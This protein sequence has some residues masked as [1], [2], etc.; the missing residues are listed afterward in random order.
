MVVDTK[1]EKEGLAE[2]IVFFLRSIANSYAAIFFSRSSW[3][4]VFLLCLTMLYPSQGLC[5]L[6]C[7]M[8]VN[9]FAISLELNRYKTEIGLYGFNAVLVGNALGA[10][11]PYN[12]TLI[13]LVFAV[14]VV[15]LLLT[16][17]LET[18][19]Q[20]Y[21]LPSLCTPFLLCLWLVLLVFQQF[22]A[23]EAGFDFLQMQ[24]TPMPWVEQISN[25]SF[26]QNVPRP[27]LLFFTSLGYIFFQ[28]NYLTGLLL[29]I[30]LLFFSRISATISLIGFL[31]A[32]FVYEAFDF[33]I[34][35]VP[36][37]YFGFNFIFT[38]MAVGG[39][40]LVS[41]KATLLWILL[42]VPPQFMVVY[43]SHRL[44][45]YFMLPT[46]SLAFCV[47]CLL[48]LFMLKNRTSSK[49]PPYF[50]FFVEATPEENVY[51][52]LVNVKRFDYLN[53]LPFCLP[54]MGEW[55]VSQGYEGAYT[56]KGLWQ[57]ALDF[58][59]EYDGKQYKGDGLSV[60]DYYCFGKPVVAVGNGE[61]VAV[62][63]D[64]EDNEIGSENR[65][66]NWGN[67]VVLKHTDDLFSIVAH[68]QKDSVRCKVGDMVRMGDLL[69]LCG[70]SGLSPYPHLHFQF[71][72]EAYIGA[73]TFSY[74]L[75]NYLR[76]GEISNYP[77]LVGIP[78]ENEVVKNFVRADQVAQNYNFRVGMCMTA[79]SDIY[80]TETWQVCTEY[81]YTLLYCWETKAKAW[82]SLR[83]GDFCFQRYVGTQKS[84]LFYFFL[85]NY[86]VLF[87]S[88]R[89][90]V[91][92]AL[93]LTLKPFGLVGLLQ[94]FL[95]PYFTFMDYKFTA[96]G[97]EN[98]FRSHCQKLTFKYVTQSADFKTVSENGSIRE[99]EVSEKKKN[100]SRKWSIHL[101]V[102]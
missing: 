77:Y 17:S 44:L 65:I 83:E 19:F 29:A 96:T 67:Y 69:G 70:N 7:C 57:H 75:S 78:A 38:A 21:G 37:V 48:F 58:N 60:K 92:E 33:E 56:H 43:S 28:A 9:A 3:L 24:N 87:L 22:E 25:L 54:F 50:S 18:I 8:L 79:T 36:F 35:H 55:K 45:S 98:S 86:R 63:N 31:F 71:Q 52:N 46:Y 95:A 89:Y 42:L 51:Y 68:L 10:L 93:P 91:E 74:P 11:F 59:I 20:K 102:K 62:C 100:E 73:P 82:F 81:G 16:V 76:Q 99:I 72:T 41:S 97:D 2:E 40:Y 5:G 15:V 80:G 12:A 39:C 61:V 64:V 101:N 49:N 32:Y 14:S 66:H 85:S 84:N 53:Y 6:F 90:E 88:E 26:W 4:G 27:L 13:S 34:F 47:V 30:S 23:C 1:I 94:D